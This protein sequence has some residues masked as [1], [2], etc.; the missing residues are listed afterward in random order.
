MYIKTQIL[1]K[2]CGLSISIFL[3]VN[4][5]NEKDLGFKTQYYKEIEST[6]HILALFLLHNPIP[7][8]ADF[9]CEIS[10]KIYITKPKP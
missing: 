9:F 10:K 3:H 2:L 6:S 1:W 5:C 8:T 7:P 4:I